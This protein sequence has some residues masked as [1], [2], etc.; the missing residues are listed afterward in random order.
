MH[1]VDVVRELIFPKQRSH[2]PF[3]TC[4]YCWSPLTSL[5]FLL[6]FYWRF[7]LIINLCC[8]KKKSRKCLSLFSLFD[9]ID[10]QETW[11][12]T[13]KKWSLIH[14]VCKMVYLPLSSKAGM[15]KLPT[16]LMIL[17][18]KHPIICP[19]KY[20]RIV[21]IIS[22]KISSYFYTFCVLCFKDL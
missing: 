2:R 5:T 17:R 13:H 6:L 8:C 9:V 14:V 18:K 7:N 11:L 4:R 10:W 16:T 1:Q 21:L 12:S 22:L 3:F 20:G 19:V 15:L